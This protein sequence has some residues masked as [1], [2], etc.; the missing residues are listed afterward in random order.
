MLNT[1]NLFYLNAWVIRAYIRT[2]S[3]YGNWSGV[4]DPQC[5][6]PDIA[7]YD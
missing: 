2:C 6:H 7:V 4:I 5:K 3:W 1:T